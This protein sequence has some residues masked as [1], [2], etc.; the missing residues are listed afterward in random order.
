MRKALR[1][2]DLNLLLVLESLDQH[3]HVSRCAEAMGLTQ[4]AISHA[5]KRLRVQFEDPLFIRGGNGLEPTAL[6]QSLI[7]QI[8]N[9]LDQSETLFLH[10]MP[11]DPATTKKHFV[12]GMPDFVSIAFA[13]AL[14]EAI[15]RQAPHAGITI[16]YADRYN[17]RSALEARDIDLVI[18]EFSNDLPK[19]IALETLFSGT[20]YVYANSVHPLSGQTRIGMKEYVE[21]DHMKISVAGNMQ[22]LM[23]E[24][25]KSLGI[26]RHIKLSLPS[27]SIV[28]KIMPLH[29]VLFTVGDFL[30]PYYDF[31]ADVT[32]LETSFT[33]P[34]Y[35]ISMAW[36][37]RD[38]HNAAHVWLRNL[39]SETVVKS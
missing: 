26:T 19:N 33:M 28:R 7:P 21:A 29:P 20:S 23:D 2:C 10:H 1:K 31:D 14:T 4:S 13:E 22:N 17:A 11:F 5:L 18:S 16:T 12:I 30:V 34:K 25:Y 8:R 24:K 38:D 36:H 37:R 27:H 32:R 15:L 3:R 39:V 9:V 6:T 35:S